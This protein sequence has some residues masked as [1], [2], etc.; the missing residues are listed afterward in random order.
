[1][2]TGKRA[3][4]PRRAGKAAGARTAATAQKRATTAEKKKAAAAAKAQEKE[5]AAVRK[6]ARIRTI[7]LAQAAWQET[8]RVLDEARKA[9]ARCRQTLDRALR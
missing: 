4:A 1:M 9:E 2:Q 7:G 8:K 6:A 3:R 5:Q